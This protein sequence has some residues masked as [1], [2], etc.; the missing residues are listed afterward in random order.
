[1]VLLLAAT[2]GADLAT[3]A[4]AADASDPAAVAIAQQVM[5]ALGGKAAWDAL[6]GIRWSFEGVVRDTVRSTR[7]HAWNKHT[8]WHRVEGLTR[9]G[10]RYVIVQNLNTGEGKAWM[11]G[12]AMEGDSLKQLLERGKALW[13]NDSYWFLMPYK[14]LDP[15]VTLTLDAP[16]TF[17][18][19]RCDR[20]A[21]HFDHVGLTPGDRYWVDVDRETHRVV[22]WDKLLEGSAPPPVGDTWEGWEQ[23]DGLWFATAHMSDDRNIATRD[24]ETV[25][26]FP[27]GTFSAP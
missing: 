22:H 26:A 13:V 2:L 23:H 20:V 4:R 17:N 18:G 19:R 5:E 9:A 10:D 6:P 14:M 11:A 24:I 8:G 16:S 12:R 27:D 3:P 7:R 15:G 25:R 21:M 1:M